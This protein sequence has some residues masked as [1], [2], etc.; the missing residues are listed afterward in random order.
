MSQHGQ[1][2]VSRRERWRFDQWLCCC[3]Q[4]NGGKSVLHSWMLYIE[5]FENI[6]SVVQHCTVCL[7]E[8]NGDIADLLARRI[9]QYEWTL[10]VMYQQVGES[11]PDLEDEEFDRSSWIKWFTNVADITDQKW[12]VETQECFW[13]KRLKKWSRGGAQTHPAGLTCG[14]FEQLLELGEGNLTA[15]NWTVQM[16]RGLPMGG[17][18]VEVTNWSV[19]RE[20]MTKS[21]FLSP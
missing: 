12:A 16:P 6:L 18:D 20:V 11:R 7:D 15:K 13:K 19:H 14:A 10:C 4:Q 17:G 2:D 3:R 5:F 9:K 8:N 1:F 21:C